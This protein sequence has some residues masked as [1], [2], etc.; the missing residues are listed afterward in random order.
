M[1]GGRA[2]RAWGGEAVARCSPCPGAPAPVGMALPP[3]EAAQPPLRDTPPTPGPAGPPPSFPVLRMAGGRCAASGWGAAPTCVTGG[4]VPGNDADV[5]GSPCG[6]GGLDHPI[7]RPSP[8]HFQSGGLWVPSL[9]GGQRSPRLRSTAEKQANA[10]GEQATGPRGAGPSPGRGGFPVG[11]A[12]TLLPAAARRA[13]PGM[14]TR[15]WSYHRGNQCLAP[16]QCFRE[17]NRFWPR[18]KRV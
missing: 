2:Q 1:P 18:T 4:R 3:R 5:Q 6:P 16:A 11:P 17:M 8:L 13:R 10:P 9:A 12:W 14:G 15:A 7:I